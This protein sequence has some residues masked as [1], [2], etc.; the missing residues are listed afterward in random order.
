[1]KVT[2]KGTIYAWVIVLAL[3]ASGYT[4]FASPSLA[5]ETAGSDG[6][7]YL[8]DGNYSLQEGS[9]KTWDFAGEVYASEANNNASDAFTCPAQSTSAY[10]FISSRGQERTGLNGWN[11][12]ANQIFPAGSKNLLEVNFTP[13]ANI[14]SLKL[15]QA[16]IK[17]AGGQYSLGVACTTNNGVTVVAA[18]YR[19][20]DVTPTTG[21][22]TALPNGNGGGDGGGGDGGGGD[23]GGGTV[24]PTLGFGTDGL[25]LTPA[26]TGTWLKDSVYYN[27]NVRNFSA[28]HDL[29]GVTARMSSIKALGVGVLVLEPIFPIS[30]TGMPGTIGDLYAPSTTATINP[31]LGTE[32]D[33]TELIAAAHTNNIKVVLTWV[34]DRIGNDSTWINE[35]SDWIRYQGFNRVSPEGAP[36]AT[37]LDFGVPELR[38]EIITE[39]KSWVTKFD[40]DGFTSSLAG[41]QPLDFWNEATYRINQIRPVAFITSSPVAGT[42][43]TNSFG[44]VK[45]NEFLTAVNT[46]A[47]GTTLNTTWKTALTGLATANRV[48]ANINYVTDSATGELGKT[49]ATRL[50]SFLNGALAMSYVA[51]GA[52]MLNAGQ[53]IAYSKSLKPYD[54]DNIAWPTKAH[55]TTA[56]LTKLAK[57]RTTNSVIS[58]GATTS[59]TT[60]VKT[61]F[62][63]KRS[64]SAGTVYY[65][66]NLTKKSLTAKVTFGAKGTVYDFTTGKKLS[67]AASQNVS[68]PASGF[69]IYSS[70]P[71][72]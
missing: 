66:G 71:V 16:S 32:T 40:L 45:R 64:G 21:E 39:M 53:E 36:H 5:E 27:V 60:S 30:Q 55:P 18:W 59:L 28:T 57:L 22:W 68:I 56:L 44:A 6:S 65:I 24:D 63:F 25:T 23:G 70:K 51:P 4:Y 43:S 46:L 62:A 12:A 47:K 37:L 38:A 26:T 13:S 2:K 17:S 10:T 8:Y 41:G 42:Y 19:Y 35:H 29:D 14:I 15:P 11:A 58:S 34:T 54:V 52:P 61:A 50:G 72:K 9:S 48:A 69:L 67:I 31:Q 20:I 1:M 3:I 49:D 33:L 7:V